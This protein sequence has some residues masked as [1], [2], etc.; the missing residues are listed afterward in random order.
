MTRDRILLI[1]D[2]MDAVH[3][4]RFALERAAFEVVCVMASEDV[5]PAA[6]ANRPDLILLALEIA[7]RDR[8]R[9]DGHSSI[10][11]SNERHANERRAN[12]IQRQALGNSE[13][14]RLCELLRLDER[15]RD[16]PIVLMTGHSRAD[17]QTI[18]CFKAGADDYIQKPFRPADVVSRARARLEEK[19]KD[20]AQ[21]VFNLAGAA[22]LE[23]HLRQELESG[24]TF[25]TLH[26]DVLDFSSF[27]AQQG[28]S[29][30]DELL[31]TVARL[32]RESAASIAP[33]AFIAHA[34]ADRFVLVTAPDSLQP[35]A[36]DIL[37]RY[38][39]AMRDNA[40]RDAGDENMASDNDVESR[41]GGSTSR[42][43]VSQSVF[44]ASPLLTSPL[45]E[46]SWPRLALAGITNEI[47][48]LRNPLEIASVALEIKRALRNRR[49]SSYLKDRRGGE[50]D[51]QR[52]PH[53]L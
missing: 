46:Y 41:Q 6:I 5:M 34:G 8:R 14:A 9:N 39:N 23:N 21:S 26:A 18:E 2:E 30:G 33:D 3:V 38:D 22:S 32:V 20:A 36:Q 53:H 40:M 52:A 47:R 49:A 17:S 1:D 19:R 27:N 25:G 35:L 10:A 12:G 42:D 51:P 4:L 15:T 24:A 31:Q 29:K 45:H 50:Y 11:Q 28:R 37:A 48:R 16:V 13:A 44:V 7:A 43:N